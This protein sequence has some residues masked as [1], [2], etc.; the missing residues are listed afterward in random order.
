MKRKTGFTC[1]SGKGESRE[2]SS[3]A[4]FPEVCEANLKTAVG[5]GVSVIHPCAPVAQAYCVGDQLDTCSATMKDCE[6][7]RKDIDPPCGP[8]PPR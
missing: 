3:C 2:D 4:L 8:L 6:E 7:G 5:D 1:W